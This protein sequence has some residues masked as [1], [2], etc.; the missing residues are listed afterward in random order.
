MSTPET[1]LA[2]DFGLRRIGIASGDSVTQSAAPRPA[3]LTGPA[4]PDWGAIAREVNALRPARLVVGAPYNV[5]G[6]EGAI[7]QAARAF[8]AELKTRFAL[9]VHLVDERFSSLEATAALR[10]ARASG[11]RRR[12]VA[13]SDIDSAAAAVILTR[14]FRGEGRDVKD[15][16]P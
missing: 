4:G 13:K 16:S 9:P 7:T 8:A 15:L 2:F 6:S 12:R 3:A 14:W 1:V 11:T 5:D 10:H